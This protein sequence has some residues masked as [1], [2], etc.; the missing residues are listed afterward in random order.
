MARPNTS[1][2]LKASGHCPPISRRTTPARSRVSCIR[3]HP[4]INDGQPTFDLSWPVRIAD[5]TI[6]V[7][8]FDGYFGKGYDAV[9]EYRWFASAFTM[10]DRQLLDGLLPAA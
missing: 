4:W 10:R 2:S 1:L 8:P 9:G 6:R 5:G 3:P 7:E